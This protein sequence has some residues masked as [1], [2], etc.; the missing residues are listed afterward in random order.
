MTSDHRTNATAA[1]GT[2]LDNLLGE[3]LDPFAADTTSVA[4]ADDADAEERGFEFSEWCVIPV[5]A[6]F[7]IG[8]MVLQFLRH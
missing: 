7:V 3:W 6:L 2:G 8:D 5:A 1:E 4:A